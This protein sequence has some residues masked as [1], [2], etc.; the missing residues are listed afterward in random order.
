MEVLLTLKEISEWLKISPQTLYKML[1]RGELPAI[2]IN[3]KW[4]FEKKKIQEWL[5][6][7]RLPKQ[8][9]QL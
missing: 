4:R 8:D 6:T 1:E 9:N 2:K 3:N 7:Q 5:H